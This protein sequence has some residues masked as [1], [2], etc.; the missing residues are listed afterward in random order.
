MDIHSE[1]RNQAKKQ[2]NEILPHT[3]QRRQRTVY[4][5]HPNISTFL[6]VIKDIQSTTYMYIKL[7]SLDTYYRLRCSESYSIPLNAKNST[8]LGRVQYWITSAT[9]IYRHY[10]I[11]EL[12]FVLL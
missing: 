1:W 4:A 7:H 12:E 3:L 6:Y 11:I 2:L 10:R 5:P 9:Q 8:L